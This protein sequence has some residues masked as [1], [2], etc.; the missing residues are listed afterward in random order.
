MN[1]KRG[2][3]INKIIFSFISIIIL[4][5]II[6]YNIFNILS[7]RYLINDYKMQLKRD[8]DYVAQTLKQKP[9]KDNLLKRDP[10]KDRLKRDIENFNRKNKKIEIKG[11]SIEEFLRFRFAGRRME[12]SMM[13]IDNDD[14]MIFKTLKEK[15]DKEIIDNIDNILDGNYKNKNYLIEY[16]NLYD[17]NDKY[18]GKLYIFIRLNQLLYIKNIFSRSIIISLFASALFISI[19]I[20]IYSKTLIKPLEKL[21]RMI[22]YY[23]LD[24]EL[25]EDEIQ[26]NDEIQS[27]Y[28]SFRNLAKRLKQKDILQKR[29][30]QNASHELKT[31]LMSI[32]GYAEAIKDGVIEGDEID[33]SLDIIMDESKRLKAIVEEIIYLSK[34]EEGNHLILNDVF[35]NDIVDDSIDTLKLIAKEKNIKITNNID[36]KIKGLIDVNRIKR[37][38]INTISNAIRYAKGNIEIFDELTN[39]SIIIYIKDDGDGFKKEDINHIFERF[40]KGSDGLSGLGLCISKTIINLHGGEIKAY[41]DNGAVIK[42]ILPIKTKRQR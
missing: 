14:K 28:E 32:Q 31:P 7:E 6:T 10:M 2:K 39:E 34:L 26:T 35:L 38:F 21:K 22:E 40:Y 41:N 19:M 25:A 11:F 12:S 1:K 37:V 16:V 30:I 20:I 15:E 42:I 5:V 9:L 23:D 27:I 36:N 18:K 13:L 24:D 17:E 29:F 33:E 4:V 8:L 3:L